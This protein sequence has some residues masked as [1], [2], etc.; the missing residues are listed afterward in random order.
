[1]PWN[2]GSLMDKDTKNAKAEAW[3]VMR[4]QY[5][6]GGYNGGPGA[7]DVKAFLEG[8]DATSSICILGASTI[9]L[10]KAALARSC[11]VTVV[12]FSEKTMGDM[13]KEL[14]SDTLTGQIADLTKPDS[15]PQ[16][17]FDVVAGD[18][19]FNRF[20]AR[21]AEKAAQSMLRL[22]KPGGLLRTKIRLG[23]YGRDIPLMQAGFEDGTLLEFYNPAT[24][25]IDYSKAVHLL[26]N[27][28]SAHGNIPSTVLQ[29]FYVLRGREKR[30]NLAE[31]IDLHEAPRQNGARLVHTRAVYPDPDTPA[32]ILITFRCE[33]HSQKD[34]G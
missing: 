26:S 31:V 25:E 8:V 34:A 18:R 17:T 6:A 23:I 10:I 5:W 29:E 11:L 16:N 13:L 32:D 21:E 33:G 12:D 2:N 24:S 27:T 4:R 15:V 30:F 28:L 20:D 19:I 3:D 1:M 14:R 22:L 9:G 7:L